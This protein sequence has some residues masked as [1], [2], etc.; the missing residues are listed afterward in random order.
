MKQLLWA[1]VLAMTASYGAAPELCDSF[2]DP[3]GRSVVDFAPPSGFLDVCSRDAALCDLVTRG[4]PQSVQTIGYFVPAEEWLRYQ[5]REL[6]GFSRY[7]I[8]QRGRTLSAKDFSDFKSYVHEK[9]GD[10]PD[11]TELPKHLKD[12]GQVPLGITGETDDSLS[13]GM[14][15]N[16]GPADGSQLVLASINIALQL[17]GWFTPISTDGSVKAFR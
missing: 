9:Q 10:I 5:K 15:M 13:M 16:L 7:L 4:Y 1:A 12:F 8:G 3:K 14:L 2:R 6:R 17:K 11:H